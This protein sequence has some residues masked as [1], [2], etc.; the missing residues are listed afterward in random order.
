M[1][2]L[3]FPEVKPYEE[4]RKR[5]YTHSPRKNNGLWQVMYKGY[6]EHLSVALSPDDLY[7]NI[8][9]LW[10]KYIVA[11]AEEFREQIVTHQGQKVL[12]YWTD[13]HTWDDEN[14]K[15]HSLAFIDLIKKDGNT[16]TDWMGGTFSTTTNLDILVRSAATL[17][18]QKAYYEFRS[19]F[20]CGFPEIILLGEVEDWENLKGLVKT[21]PCYDEGM[22]EWKGKLNYVLT[23]FVAADSTDE[24]FWQAPFTA[25]RY[26]SGSQANFCGWLTVFNP[27]N[28]KGTWNKSSGDYY[29][30]EDSDILDLTVDFQIKLFDAGGTQY[31]TLSIAAGGVTSTFEEGRL[32]VQNVLAYQL[33]E[34]NP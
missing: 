8:C 26:G 4:I 30:L 17:A 15:A 20:L 12:E 22:K 28:E 29:F 27:F 7:N 21:M 24:D 19:M 1:R 31:G 5:P 23:K 14:I 6:N 11:H 32:F 9:C 25:Q 10:A 13:N 34:E 16:S 33:S 2:T 18:S 3:L